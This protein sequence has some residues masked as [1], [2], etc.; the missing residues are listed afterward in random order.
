MKK[1][2]FIGII[3]F[4][5]YPFWKGEPLF[6]LLHYRDSDL[7]VDRIVNKAMCE[8]LVQ[9]NK[10][11]GK[12]DLFRLPYLSAVRME[13]DFSIL[14]DVEKKCDSMEEAEQLFS[15][16]C[17]EFCHR[18][19]SLPIIRPF[20]GE[21]PVTPHSIRIILGFVNEDGI[22]YRPPYIASVSMANDQL[23]FNYFI[24]PHY[25]AYFEKPAASIACMQKLYS[26]GIPRTK[27]KLNQPV[28][29]YHFIWNAVPALNE[30]FA[31]ASAFAKRHGLEPVAGNVGPRYTE[32]RPFQFGLRGN[33]QLILLSARKLIATC[34][35]EFFSSIQKSQVAI[36]FVRERKTW[37][38]Q[39]FSGDVPLRDHVGLRM[40]F[41]DEYVNRVS[42][43]YI[44]EI[45]VIGESF[46]YYTA[47]EG[48]RL[49]LVYEESW[50]DAMKFLEQATKTQ[51]SKES[52][53]QEVSL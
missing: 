35:K 43:P 30:T 44:A 13:D 53:Q 24:G 19:S 12:L 1:I 21:F 27:E 40:S 25:E 42:E 18:L 10:W 16:V 36:E 29:T 2:I 34:A 23:E 9:P 5:S 7:Y 20:L 22:C 17:A 51:E 39:K 49:V 6:D 38:N 15:E 33:Q 11:R 41:W 50:D 28:P 52:P 4:L 26:Q 45:R 48:Q 32:N 8:Q 31:F 37:F 46:K 47:D 3:L 14:I